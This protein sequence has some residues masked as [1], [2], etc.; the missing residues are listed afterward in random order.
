MSIRIN[1]E[2]KRGIICLPDIKI[3]YKSKTFFIK[4]TGCDTEAR[5]EIN[6]TVQRALKKWCKIGGHHKLV[7]K[8]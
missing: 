5:K 2:S 3:Y 1:L 6:G 8:G 4:G 7:R